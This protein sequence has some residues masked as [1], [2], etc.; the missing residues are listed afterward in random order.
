MAEHDVLAMLSVWENCSYSLLDAAA[1]GLGVVASDVGGNPEILPA[2]LARATP[3]DPTP[4]RRRSSDQGLDAAGS[5]RPARAGRR[6]RH[7]RADR[8][9]VRRDR[10]GA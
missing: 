9:D 4:W 2:Q 6:S 5:S 1:R 7:V 8:R 3:T 10:G